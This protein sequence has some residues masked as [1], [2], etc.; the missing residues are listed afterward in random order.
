MGV[1]QICG[2]YELGISGILLIV[3]LRAMDMSEYDVI[4]RMD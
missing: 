1:D 4:L 3:D 2:G